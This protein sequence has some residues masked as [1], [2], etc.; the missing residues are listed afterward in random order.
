MS[1][2][3]LFVFHGARGKPVKLSPG[4]QVRWIG[5]DGRSN[6]GIFMDHSAKF[7]NTSMVYRILHILV[8]D[9]GITKIPKDMIFQLEVIG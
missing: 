9:A 4:D 1:S 7:E 6:L 3:E 8:P 5:V 2:S